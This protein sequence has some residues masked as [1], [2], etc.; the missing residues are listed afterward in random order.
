MMIRPEKP[1]DA[2]AISAV[3]EAAFRD[4]EHSDQT[5]HLIIERLR[6]AD[7]LSISLVAEDSEGI[8]GHIAFSHVRVEQGEGSWYG[9]GPLSV[10]P[11][12]QGHG[13]GSRLVKAGL[14]M[15]ERM[16]AAGCVVAGD[17]E[18]YG[19]FGF[20]NS[21]TLNTDGIPNEYFMFVS[22]HGNKPSGI[23]HY[24]PGFYGD[25]VA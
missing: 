10:A 20:V 13:I 25:K 3:T 9:L 21:E 11:D 24:H 15:L 19:R 4:A 8:V 22:L 18:F 17:P 16:Q 1:A 7:A 14:D 23:V 12:R 2:E 6:A 5:E